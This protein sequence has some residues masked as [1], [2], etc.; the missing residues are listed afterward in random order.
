[1][2]VVIRC[3]ASGERFVFG[4][5][6]FPRWWSHAKSTAK[7]GEKGK[8]YAALY[9]ALRRHK[10]ETFEFELRQ[11]NAH[12]LLTEERRV[13]AEVAKA[14]REAGGPDLRWRRKRKERQAPRP[15]NAAEAIVV[16][17]KRKRRLRKRLAS[18]LAAR[19]FA[20]ECGYMDLVKDDDEK[21]AEVRERLAL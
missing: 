17:E 18:L 21:I 10:E 7:T 13:R 12:R 16:M 2:V 14:D 3:R 8:R 1:M 11:C 20:L 6:D 19:A 5:E 4:V 15:M 9:D